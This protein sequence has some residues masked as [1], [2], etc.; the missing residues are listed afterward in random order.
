MV[1]YNRTNHPQ[2]LNRHMLSLKSQG[3]L[4]DVKEGGV[5]QGR[6]ELRTCSG[7]VLYEIC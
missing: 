2:V 6:V 7:P 3:T 1:H 4:T 5:P